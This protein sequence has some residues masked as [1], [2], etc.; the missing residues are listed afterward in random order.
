[1]FYRLLIAGTIFFWVLMNGALLR[2]WINPADRRFLSIPPEHVMQLAF[3]HEK[4][5]NLNVYQGTRHIGY[6]LL[7]PQRGASGLYVLHFK[8]NLLLELPFMSQQPYSFEGKAWFDKELN[9]QRIATTIDIPL[10]KVGV[11]LD[12]D[13]GKKVARCLI[14][15]NI[16]PAVETRLPL[17]QYGVNQI[18]DAL[19]IDPAVVQQITVSAKHAAGS[20]TSITLS[21][22]KAAVKIQDG[23]TQGYHMVLRQ[24]TSP[25]VEADVTQLGEIVSLKSVFGLQL[26]RQN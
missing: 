23:E 21:A 22:H 2:L 6:L 11:E 9:T 19:G 16:A 14:Q 10:P 15:Q 12:I 20:S 3:Q 1:M 13:L 17:N 4:K 18:L 25:V 7:S 8:G 26:E 5:S 24:S